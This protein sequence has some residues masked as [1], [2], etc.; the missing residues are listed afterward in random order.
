M[1][2]FRLDPTDPVHEKLIGRLQT[3]RIGW[4]GRTGRDGYPHA[5][6]VWFL[7]HEEQIVVF[8]QPNAAKTKNLRADPRALLHLESGPSGE[9]MQV[10]Q[11]TAEL[12]D[13]PTAVWV[14][15]LGDQYLAKYADGLAA[16]GW[17]MEQMA[18]DYSVTIVLHPEK[19]IAW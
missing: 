5:V 14:N 2:G 11:G 8:S 9:F 15:R 16:L 6:P 1:S 7:W 4:L 17:D 12:S 19:V 3:E 13:E 10:L 18:S